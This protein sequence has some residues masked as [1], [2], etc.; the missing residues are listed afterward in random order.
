MF[1]KTLNEHVNSSIA[2]ALFYSTVQIL[3]SILRIADNRPIIYGRLS[4]FLSCSQSCSTQLIGL[5]CFLRKSVLICVFDG[6]FC[7]D[8]TCPF[9]AF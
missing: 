5:S 9:Y 3:Y 4:V 6:C 1:T 8:A 2:P 7:A